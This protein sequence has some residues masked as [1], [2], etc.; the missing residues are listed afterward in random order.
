MLG[1]TWHY[2]CSVKLLI[3]ISGDT[4]FF[5][6]LSS[7]SITKTLIFSKKE[8]CY[9]VWDVASF[10]WRRHQADNSLLAV[11][12]SSHLL[13][14]KIP[15]DIASLLF[16]CLH[17]VVLSQCRSGPVISHHSHDP[18]H[19]NPLLRKRRK[20]KFHGWLQSHRTIE[21]PRSAAFP[22][23]LQQPMH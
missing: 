15:R 23:Q 9:L 14:I 21:W 6:S 3:A 11:D 22:F 12:I 7:I 20:T 5:H 2:L 4:R 8:V 10:T 18:Q 19:L 16:G 17:F 1:S 13:R